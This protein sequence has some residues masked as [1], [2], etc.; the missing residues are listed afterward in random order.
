M[1]MRTANGPA[2]GPQR[3]RLA[4]LVATACATMGLGSAIAAAPASAPATYRVVPLAPNSFPAGINNRGQ[5]AFTEFVGDNPRARFYDG[6]IVRDLGTFGGPDSF[7][8]ALNEQGQVAGTAS[9]ATEGLYHAFRWSR[10]SGLVDLNRP[11][12]GY[13]SANGINEKGQVV[14]A[15]RFSGASPIFHAFRWSPHTGMVDLGSLGPTASSSALAINDAGTATGFSDE[16]AGPLLTLAVKWPAGGGV[17]PLNSFP[18]I[19]SIG[20]DINSAGQIVGGAAFDARLSDQAFFWTRAGGLQGLGTEPS[21]LSW[22]DQINEKGLVIGQLYSSPVDRNGFIWSR[23]SGLL[24]VGTPAVDSS[25]VADVNNR[26]QVVGSLNGRGYLWTRSGG[27]VDLT[28]RVVGA[29][30]ELTLFSGMA[31]NDNG[32]IVAATNAGTLVLLVPNTCHALAPV[33]GPV[34]YTDSARANALLSFSAGFTDVDLRDTHK[35][36]W[37]WGDGSKT[38]GTVSERGGTGSVSGQHAYRA[39]GIYTARLTLTDSSGKSSSV[40]R[41]VIVSG[42]G[43]AIAGEGAFAAPAATVTP[44]VRKP[45]I[46]N[47]AF[48]SEGPGARKAA[49]EVNVAGMALR[50]SQVESVTNDGTRVQ[51]AGQG[52]VNGKVGYRF[53]LTATAGAKTGGKDRIHVR[54]AH[55][56]PGTQREVV[57]YDNGASAGGE[58]RHGA[59]GNGRR[60]GQRGAG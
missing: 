46:G 2:R 41:K 22:A 44:G 49:V 6:A 1:Q 35:A 40:E 12:A 9:T 18:S 38:V 59:G 30:P 16:A 43:A 57:D 24:L 23:D 52:S 58:S 33:A 26:G 53:T 17:I 42:T 48:L 14:G 47:F 11:G 21:Y 31:I 54:I 27:F 10:H 60:R 37:S 29:P 4:S 3:W 36:V 5:V 56:E 55:S 28:S 20:Y 13:S 19:A 25:D 34:K 8:S 45:S 39:A 15:A 7:A 50:S 32:T 51:Y